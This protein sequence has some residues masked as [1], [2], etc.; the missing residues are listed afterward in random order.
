ML[1]CVQL[2]LTNECQ[3]SLC[4]RGCFCGNDRG[5]KFFNYSA[6]GHSCPFGV[7]KS[8]HSVI[9]HHTWQ[10][11]R[12]SVYSYIY[13]RRV[14][15]CACFCNSGRDCGIYNSF[16]RLYHRLFYR[17]PCVRADLRAAQNKRK[18]SKTAFFNKIDNCLIF[19]IFNN[20][21]LRRLFY[22]VYQLD[23]IRGGNGSGFS[24]VSTRRFNQT[25]Y[26]H[27][28][29]AKTKTNSSEVHK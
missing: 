28:P 7:K 22:D 16:G 9:R 21:F 8:I 20:T 10:F 17:K 4:I 2:G 3:E 1:T 14:N 19:G 25:D 24:A 29:C 15:W 27:P 5:F 23:V 13:S 26:K 18:K 12:R 6:S 11:L